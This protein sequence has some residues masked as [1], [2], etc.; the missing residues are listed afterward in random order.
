[1][2]VRVGCSGNSEENTQNGRRNFIMVDSKKAT[3]LRFTLKES[4]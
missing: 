4:L 3:N 1:M 2:H